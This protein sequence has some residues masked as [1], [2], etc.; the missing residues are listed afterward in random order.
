ML[1]QLSEGESHQDITAWEVIVKSFYGKDKTYYPFV[2]T[3]LKWSAESD[4]YG[5]ID[6]HGNSKLKR[7]IEEIGIFFLI[8][9]KSWQDM[10]L[11]TTFE[12]RLSRT[13]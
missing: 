6:K 10:Y 4:H 5:M 9:C 7:A 13:P 2:N 1:R 3:K 11:V 12:S 8:S